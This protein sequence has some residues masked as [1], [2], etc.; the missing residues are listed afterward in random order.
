MILWPKLLTDYMKICSVVNVRVCVYTDLY[1]FVCYA[2]V[3]MQ[4]SEV[5]SV[6]VW[7]LCS[8]HFLVWHPVSVAL[9]AIRALFFSFALYIFGLPHPNILQ[10][11]ERNYNKFTELVFGLCDAKRK[12]KKRE[13]TASKKPKKE[14][15]RKKD[16][17]SNFRYSKRKI[18]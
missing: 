2:M 5:N 8:S 18:W 12:G 10:K 7:F 4:A 1:Y 13:P 14:D 3:S 17:F 15:G 11:K 9:S 16:P 6:W